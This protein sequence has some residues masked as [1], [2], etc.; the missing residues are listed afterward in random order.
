MINMLPV[1]C[2][3]VCVGVVI[4]KVN[5]E[6]VDLPNQLKLGHMLRFDL[7]NTLWDSSEELRSQ[8]LLPWQC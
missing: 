1:L 2:V 5:R 3:C 7:L 6:E 8:Y 4:Y